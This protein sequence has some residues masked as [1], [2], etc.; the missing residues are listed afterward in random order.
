LRN[1][2]K[3]IINILSTIFKK[4]IEEPINKPLI[5]EIKPGYLSNHFSQEE[6]IRSQTATRHSIDNTPNKVQLQNLK[7]LS[8]DIL[9][10][11][12]DHYNKPIHITS[13]FRCND[14]NTKIGSS[15]RSQHKKGEAA[16]FIISEA[17]ALANIWRWIIMESALDFD[18][19]ILE[20][21]SW[22]HISYKKNSE[23]RNKISV[24][25]KI[26]GKTKYTHF[27][28]EQIIANNGNRV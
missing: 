3:L 20:F 6:L 4:K 12:R 10:P 2:I 28:K 25:K 27:T 19:I 21:D 23:N 26:N 18:Q 22:I 14:L 8:I 15:M 16:D 11:I 13:G 1:I 7:D 9:D 5:K 17:L 24:A